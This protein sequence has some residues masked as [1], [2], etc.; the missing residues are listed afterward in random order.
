MT[1]KERAIKSLRERIPVPNG[2]MFRTIPVVEFCKED[3]MRMFCIY[4]LRSE[5]EIND[6]RGARDYWAKRRIE[7]D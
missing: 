3:I 2:L 1:N 4:K 5:R 6:L 7:N